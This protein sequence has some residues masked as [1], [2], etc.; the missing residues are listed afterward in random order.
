MSTTFRRIKLLCS[1]GLVLVSAAGVWFG[2][3]RVAQATDEIPFS[4]LAEP[5][6]TAPTAASLHNPTL[7]NHDWYEF[8]GRYQ[9]A[10]PSSAWLP[11]D[12]NNGNND[13]P[14]DQLQDW[15]LWFLDGT[16]IIE[17]DPESV[18]AQSDEGIQMRPYDWGK[19]AHQIAGIYQVIYD[20]TPC[21]SYQFQ[22]YGQSRPE[23]P[24]DDRD[25]ALKVGIDRT[26]WHPDSRSDPAVHGSFPNSTVW[27]PTQLYKLFYGP[28]SVTAEALN[29]TIVVYTYGD[30]PGGRYHRVLW[31]TGSFQ[32]VTPEL[33]QDPDSL[34]APSGITNPTVIPGSTSASVGWT[35]TYQAL[36]Q[37]LY[38]PLTSGETPPE[39]PNKVYLPFMTGGAGAAGDWVWTTLDKTL[40]FAH[41]TTL[42]NLQPGSSYEY[43]ILSRGFTGSECVT[44]VSAPAT[45]TTNN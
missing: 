9:S 19:S 30:A 42:S 31:D 36:G 43:I 45:F 21:L 22:M 8:D 2:P 34:P 27:G 13:I 40:T 3:Q 26:G 35:T 16:A 32:D 6:V 25:A 7:D 15:R 12:D 20:A 37:V 29:T 18:Y 17:T 38:R 10:Y 4:P 41:N 23:D 24:N 28:L 1:A 11:D 5:G 39:Y 33:I 44:L 14:I